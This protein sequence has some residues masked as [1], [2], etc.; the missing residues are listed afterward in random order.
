[1]Q[2]PESDVYSVSRQ[3]L[4]ARMD[5]CMGGRVAEEMVFGAD[6]VTTGA[7]SDM[8]QATSIATEMVLR[9]GM[10]EEAIGLVYRSPEDYNSLSDE[11]K[12]KVDAQIRGLMDKSYARAKRLLQTHRG[13]LNTI[14][15]ALLQYETLTGAE[16][17]ALIRGE[18]LSHRV[19]NGAGGE[20]GRV[21]D[22][23]PEVYSGKLGAT[24]TVANG[25]DQQ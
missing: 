20:A 23:V 2:L 16:L 22:Q 10:C 7:S 4:L 1:M 12:L 18:P 24:T 15:E 21:I 9:Y 3:E 17:N 11:A 19:A 8:Q 13:T 25:V 14:A 6:A 5:V